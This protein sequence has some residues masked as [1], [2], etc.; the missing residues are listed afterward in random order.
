M[1]KAIWQWIYIVSEESQNCHMEKSI[2]SFMFAE[3]AEMEIDF[4]LNILFWLK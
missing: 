1:L 4:S 3:A 2:N